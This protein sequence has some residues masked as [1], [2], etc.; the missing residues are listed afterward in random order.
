MEQVGKKIWVENSA[1]C[2]HSLD[3]YVLLIA[4]LLRNDSGVFDLKQVRIHVH[5]LTLQESLGGVLPENLGGGV[6][7][8]PSNP[9]PISDQNI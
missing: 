1:G 4:L 5:R 6:W 9:Y 7:R 2:S 8:T 3:Y